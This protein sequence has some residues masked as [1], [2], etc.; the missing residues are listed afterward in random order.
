METAFGD[1][2]DVLPK[3][4]PRF[5]VAKLAKVRAHQRR[6]MPSGHYIGR[7]EVR[8]HRAR[9]TPPRGWLSHL[10]ARCRQIALP[11]M[12]A[13]RTGDKRVWPW[14]P[15]KSIFIGLPRQGK[16]D[17]FRIRDAQSPVQATQFSG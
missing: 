1:A 12:P 5:G 7:P 4:D 17:R 3:Y 13:Q 15:I 8:N 6:A 10:P 2:A 11:R 9:R 16:P 14:Q